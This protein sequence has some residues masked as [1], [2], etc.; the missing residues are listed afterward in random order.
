MERFLAERAPDVAFYSEDRGLVSPGGEAEWVLVVDPI[1]GTR[2]AMAGLRGGLRLGG[3][4]AAG[5]DGEPTMG[6][7]EA[8][9][10]VEI[11]SGPRV[12]RRARRRARA[13]A[14]LSAQR[15]PLADVLGLRAARPPGA[16]HRRGA[17]RADRRL[18]G[19]RRDLR[20]RLGD[21]ST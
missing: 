19:R 1:D 18:L 14:A 5:L 11:K 12:R 17:R 7:V 3:R 4:G 2:P 16:G 10:V 21:A 6:D 13:G 8:G 9:C 15:G 20:P